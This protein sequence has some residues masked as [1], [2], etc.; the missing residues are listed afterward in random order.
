MLYPQEAVLE[1]FEMTHFDR[2]I[3]IVKA[4]EAVQEVS[5]DYYPLRPIQ[6]WLTDTNFHRAKST[7]MNNGGLGRLEPEVDMERLAEAVNGVLNAHDIFRC[8]LVFHPE[9]GELCQRFD[10]EV[11]RVVV[12]SLSEEAF[13]ER[14]QELKHPYDL[15]DHPLYR[16]HIWAC[17][18]S[19]RTTSSLRRMR[20]GPSWW[21][22]CAAWAP[23]CRW[24]S[25]W[26]SLASLSSGLCTRCQKS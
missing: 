8:R 11:E 1:V 13:E 22:S 2:F 18:C 7:M 26:L 4:G 6:R 21:S 25:C 16:I 15:I 17:A 10:G 9:T 23:V 24:S 19:C 12:E 20:R 5:R 14:R 3:H